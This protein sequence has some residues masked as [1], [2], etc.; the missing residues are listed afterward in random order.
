MLC[1]LIINPEYFLFRLPY[2]SEL[3]TTGV[4]NTNLFF[5]SSIVQ[6]DMQVFSNCCHIYTY[7]QTI[8]K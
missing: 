8:R 4:K 3:K 1:T 6:V 7:I 5:I 2:E